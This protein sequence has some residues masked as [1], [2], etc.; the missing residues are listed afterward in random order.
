MSLLSRAG[1]ALYTYRFLR[2]LTQ[3]WVDMDAYKLGI[4]DEKGK[5]IK[6]DRN[7][8]EEKAA[9]TTFHRLAFNLKR[10][11]EKLPFGKTKLASYA[12]ALFLLREE[13][14]LSEDELMSLLDKIGDF[15]T[16]INESKDW[17]QMSDYSL[18][19]GTYTLTETILSPKTGENIALKGTQ[20]VVSEGCEPVDSIL[21]QY[22]YKV[23]H[24]N[25]KHD[26]YISC[27]DIKR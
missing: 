6:K 2:I 20:V 13:M 7:T 16:S 26:I 1:D 21:G 18:A 11:L 5:V 19:P 14:E 9:F 3:S 22:I 10:L 8:S 12:S 23:S 15:D 24:K 27:E 17:K 25:T 4:I